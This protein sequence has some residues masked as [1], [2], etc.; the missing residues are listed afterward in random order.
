M[1]NLNKEWEKLGS[2]LKK[3][4]GDHPPKN[5]SKVEAALKQASGLGTRAFD[6]AREELEK[7]IVD[8]QKDN[9]TMR[10][11][12]TQAAAEAVA[13][14]QAGRNSNQ[15]KSEA[16]DKKQNAAFQETLKSFFAHEKRC[17]D[18]ITKD[19]E[20]LAKHVIEVKKYKPG[21]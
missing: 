10:M 12:L 2:D 1:F 21:R 17:T 16:H 6:D 11:L 4:V 14:A 8:L 5:G 19:L 13:F 15:P 9:A 20:E 18:E 3:A 7:Q